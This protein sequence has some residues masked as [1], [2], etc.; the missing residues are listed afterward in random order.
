M[1][2]HIVGNIERLWSNSVNTSWFESNSVNFRSTSNNSCT[3]NF[4]WHSFRSTFLQPLQV[5][6]ARAGQQILILR[7]RRLYFIIRKFLDGDRCIWFCLNCRRGCVH[8][9]LAIYIHTSKIVSYSVHAHEPISRKQRPFTLKIA[10]M[11]GSYVVR[12]I[13]HSSNTQCK[14]FFN[15]NKVSHRSLCSFSDDEDSI[16]I[17]PVPEIPAIAKHSITEVHRQ[18]PYRLI[19]L[20]LFCQVDPESDTNKFFALTQEDRTSFFPEAY[21]ISSWT[22]KMSQYFDSVTKRLVRAFDLIG[23]DHI[24]LRKPTADILSVMKSNCNELD[25]LA[26]LIL[27]C[28]LAATHAVWSS[29]RIH[30]W[31]RTR[32]WQKVLSITA[33]P[34]VE[35]FVLQFSITSNRSFC[36]G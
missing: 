21:V 5:V 2:N 20:Q 3:G 23:Y 16:E 17:L 19:N 1:C 35:I 22:G 4:T 12:S 25:S 11:R 8:A 28:R 30:S 34:K 27:N 33:F 6:T 14:R 7:H 36:A 31:W 18:Y 24:M 13:F 26:S 15:Y 9:T 10:Q 29:A 32:N